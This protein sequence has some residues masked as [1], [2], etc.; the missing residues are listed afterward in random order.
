MKTV[1]SRLFLPLFAAALAVNASL[2]LAAADSPE[3][4]EARARLLEHFQNGRTDNDD[5]VKQQRAK[6]AA[7]QYISDAKASSGAEAMPRVVN[8]DFPGGP[9]SSLV[10]LINQDKN[11]GLNII[12]EKNDLAVELPAFSLRNADAGSLA[13]ALDS[14]LRARG[15]V[16]HSGNRPSPGLSPVFVLRKI[17]PREMPGDAM[18]ELRSFQLS[19]YLPHQSVDDIVGAMRAAW[20]LDPANSPA[21]LRLKFHPATGILLVSGPSQGINVVRT[22]LAELR[23][24]DPK[25][26]VQPASP[27]PPAEKR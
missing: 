23:R 2:P 3:L 11:S 25:L 20:E 5:V 19:P 26:M 22:V 9:A 16:L 6:I 15:Y 24:A 1:R 14:L 18:P 10:N 7:L 13:S 27:P 12:G 4:V 8:V 17:A 21:A